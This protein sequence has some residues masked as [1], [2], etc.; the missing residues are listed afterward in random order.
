MHRGQ[1]RRNIIRDR[2]LATTRGV[3][4]DANGRVLSASRPSYSVYV[5]PGTIDMEK[6]WPLLVK[7]VRLDDS[8]RQTFETKIKER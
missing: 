8:E 6:V 5:T 2:Y 3:I 4:R 7:L 1:A